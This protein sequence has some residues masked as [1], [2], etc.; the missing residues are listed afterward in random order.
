LLILDVRVLAVIAMS[1]LAIFGISNPGY[2]PAQ[3]APSRVVRGI[4][5]SQIWSFA[6]SPSGDQIA[7]TSASGRLTLRPFASGSQTERSLP[8][9]GFAWRVAFS[10]D[11]R[12]LAAV[13]DG[14]GVYFW[15]LAAI[16][17]EPDL[18]L[19]VPTQRPKLLEI[20][21]DGQFLA[22]TMSPEG[23]I[24][25]WDLKARSERMVLHHSSL[26]ESMAFSPDSQWLAAASSHDPCIALWDLR[27]GSR[28]AL[29]GSVAAHGTVLTFS[30]DGA[31]LALAHL[32]DHHAELWDVE[33][34][35]KCRVFVGHKRPVTSIAFSP[36]GSSFATASDDGTVA[37]WTVE[38]GQ[39]QA[40]L[41]TGAT[42][43]V[44]VTFSPDG[45]SLLL[46]TGDDDDVRMWDLAGIQSVLVK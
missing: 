30:P 16:N 32:S 34:R 7:T 2:E 33:R 41:N 12:A 4:S 8:F 42:C 46:A 28:Q 35:R 39:R 18:L 13:G 11:G 1:L 9:P 19:R 3:L 5:G 17:S 15:N 21:P 37:L 36:D 20:S 44:A 26:V 40:S 38:T 24:L 25:V 23:T 10:A 45:R 29:L 14:P 31:F 27:T 22:L 6:L 43:L